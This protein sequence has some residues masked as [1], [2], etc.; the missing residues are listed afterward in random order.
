MINK[1]NISRELH[2]AQGKLSILT[3]FFSVLSDKKKGKAVAGYIEECKTT[4][5]AIEVHLKK[6]QRLL[7]KR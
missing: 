7:G 3:A 6:C 5:K 2:E 1:K 4:I